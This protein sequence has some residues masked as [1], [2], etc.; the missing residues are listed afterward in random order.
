M[1]NK[2]EKLDLLAS[3]ISQCELAATVGQSK[4]KALEETDKP[5]IQALGLAD[6]IQECEL[7]VQSW[8]KT[9]GT[10]KLNKV[11]SFPDDE[12]NADSLSVEATALVEEIKACHPILD[13][14]KNDRKASEKRNKSN[15]DYA[16]KKDCKKYLQKGV[17]RKL[18]MML[19][20]IEETTDP[21]PPPGHSDVIA[22][23]PMGSWNGA[24]VSIHTIEGT[25]IGKFVTLIAETV[26]SKAASLEAKLTD[27]DWPLC[28][29]AQALRI[30]LRHVYAEGG[31]SFLAPGIWGYRLGMHRRSICGCQVLEGVAW[32]PF[33]CTPLVGPNIVSS[34]GDAKTA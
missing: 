16:L 26:T 13:S 1:A 29:C 15:H 5:R 28:Q 2:K 30:R 32:P 23:T 3:A 9:L 8:S 22:T 11:Q 21:N 25:G 34:R 10:M 4:L 7:R 12:E 19:V 33:W 20:R 24:K 14:I 18:A 31:S 6:T 17:C 27:K